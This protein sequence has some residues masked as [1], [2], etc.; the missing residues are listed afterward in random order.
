MA[1]KYNEKIWANIKR[2]VRKEI[3]KL[4]EGVKKE[5]T[6]LVL[7]SGKTG[8]TYRRNGVEHQASAP[9]EP[10]AS[11]TG[12]TLSQFRTETRDS[13]FTGAFVA[14]GENA[15][16]LELGTSKM[17]ARPFARPALANQKK[18]IEQGLKDAVKR[19]AR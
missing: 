4:T 8:R 12:T 2:E 11:D 6:D 1:V 10:F 7:T 3:F 17:D 19:G 5:A 14:G 9:G 16:R 13:G 15:R 18:E